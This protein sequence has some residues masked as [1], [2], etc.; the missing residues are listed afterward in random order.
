MI[1]CD[2]DDN[3]L[4]VVAR[5]VSIKSTLAFTQL[6]RNQQCSNG[7]LT[8][9]LSKRQS[10]FAYHKDNAGYQGTCMAGGRWAQMHREGGPTVQG[11]GVRHTAS[12]GPQRDEAVEGG[13][14]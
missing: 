2:V 1:S 9:P 6:L 4:M 12:D 14:R 13:G 3:V 5:V 11:H 7:T 8:G 10:H